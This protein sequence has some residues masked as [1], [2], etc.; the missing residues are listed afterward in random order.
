MAP[1]N[2]AIEFAVRAALQPDRVS[3]ELDAA[4]AGWNLGRDRCVL[5]RRLLA[6]ATTLDADE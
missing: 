2:A 5:R 6:L 4:R 3:L 1:N